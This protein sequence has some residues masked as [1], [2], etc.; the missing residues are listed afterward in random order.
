[1]N[2]RELRT[3]VDAPT[4]QI[5]EDLLRHWTPI[6]RDQ[7]RA[8]RTLMDYYSSID[9]QQAL[10]MLTRCHTDSAVVRMDRIQGAGLGLRAISDIPRG[11]WVCD[12][13]NARDYVRQPDPVNVRTLPRNAVLVGQHAYCLTT[14]VPD[15]ALGSY[16]N[17]ATK[18]QRDKAR[19]SVLR[20]N[21]TISVSPSRHVTTLRASR[22]IS[23]GE[24]IYAAYGQLYGNPK[25][26]RMTHAVYVEGI[27]ERIRRHLRVNRS[28]S[29]RHVARLRERMVPEIVVTSPTPPPTP[30]LSIS[31]RP[32][33]LL[34]EK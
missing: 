14:D 2:D 16:A 4:L 11:H 20:N 27:K 12:L 26:T 34:T 3:L 29:R 6:A 1:M 18:D 15:R 7:E 17:C 24:F 31:P 33:V 10:R 19:T 28:S 9:E 13:S 23:A 25:H 30:Q 22:K 21:C 8:V 5:C 32:I